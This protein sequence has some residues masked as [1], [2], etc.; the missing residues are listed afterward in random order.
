MGFSN[1]SSYIQSGNVT[2]TSASHDKKRM[3]GSIAENI[4]KKFGFEINVLIKS[5]DELNNIIKENPYSEIAHKDLSKLHITFLLNQASKSAIL[6]L[7]KILLDSDEFFAVKDIIY[8]Y[9][10]NGYSRTKL[11]NTHLER[12]L[13]VSATTRNFKTIYTLY[14]QY[15]D[16]N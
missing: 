11:T 14:H 15:L 5:K 3:A 4:A 10:P 12:I 1:V 6:Q 7:N 16:N 9:C 8:L 2:F 13:G